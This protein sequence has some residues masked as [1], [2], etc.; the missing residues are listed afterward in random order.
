MKN[1]TFEGMLLG[2]GLR[3]GIIVSRF[4]DFITN[5]MLEG[6]IDALLRHGVTEDDIEITRVTGSFEIPW[7]PRSWPTASVTTR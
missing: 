5:K 3:F 2:E 4:N 6:A 1:T 7:Q